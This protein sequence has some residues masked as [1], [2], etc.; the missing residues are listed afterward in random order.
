M[1]TDYDCVVA[2]GGPAGAFA[3]HELARAGLRV[4]I[5]DPASGRP[6]LEGLG[7]RVEQ[8]LRARGLDGALA[9]ASGPLPRSVAWAGLSDNA[10]GE[11]LVERTRFDAA[12]RRAAVAAGARLET[13]RV[14]RVL[15]ADPGDGVSL[16]LSSGKAVTAR[17]MV[18]ARGRQAPSRDRLKGPETLAISGY[19]RQSAEDNGTFVAATPEGWLWRA[20]APGFKTWVQVCIDAGDLEGSG[21]PALE[22]RVARFLAQ[23]EIRDAFADAVLRRPLQAR[24]AGLVLAA[25]ELRLPVIPVGDAAVAIDPLSGHGL[26]WALSSA[27]AAVPAA[28]TLLEM[29]G[30]GA[31]LAARF[32]RDRVVGTFWRQART[33]RDF[34]RL[35][36]ALAAHDFW[37]RRAA[38]P[39]DDPAHPEADA[40]SLV[41]RVVVDGNRLAERDVLVT[42]LDPGGVAFV[43]GIPVRDL[44]AFLAPGTPRPPPETVSPQ[45]RTALGWMASRGLVGETGF[46]GTHQHMT[47]RDTA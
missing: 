37:R 2:G 43:A 33:G 20:A 44:A 14:R 34:H 8:L 35:E 7:A 23:P 11:R 24:S 40:V 12:L 41:R 36:T 25:P 9:A 42:P 4:L 18:D 3:A 29:P 22:A 13:A 47:T 1:S 31:G 30:E 16:L 10:S 17:L 32:Y 26:F 6:R 19:L 28:L 21:Q 5:V 46:P 15:A 27:L 39:D 38:W 45:L